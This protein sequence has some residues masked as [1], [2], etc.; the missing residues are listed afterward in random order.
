MILA[1]SSQKVF[2]AG[3]DILEMYKPQVGPRTFIHLHMM[4]AAE[5][6]STD[7]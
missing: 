5:S 4:S 3:L 1:S 6:S 7:R 2:S